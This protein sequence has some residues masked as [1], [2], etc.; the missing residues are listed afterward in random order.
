VP[1]YVPTETPQREMIRWLRRWVDRAFVDRQLAAQHVSLT[2]SQRRMR[3][4]EIAMHVAQGLEYIGSAEQS[5]M[6]TRP[7]P[8]FYAAEN[9]SKALVMMEAGTIAASDFRVHGLTGGKQKRYSIENLACKAAPASRDVWSRI[10]NATQTDL[11]NISWHQDGRGVVGTARAGRQPRAGAPGRRLRFGQLAMRMPELH[12]DVIAAAW[13][14]PSVVRVESYTSIRNTG[15]PETQT[16]SLRLDHAHNASLKQLIVGAQNGQLKGYAKVFDHLNSLE[17]SHPGPNAVAP[18]LRSDVL[19]DLFVDFGTPQGALSDLALH[20]AALF[21][22]SD[23]VR[24]QPEQWKRLL[25][26]HVSEAVLVD[27]YL[28][29]ATRKV[30]NMILNGLLGDCVLFLARP[31]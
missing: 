19:G 7:L 14:T 30:P 22:L 1:T 3:A 8:L 2:A 26:E 17:Y 9:L 16:F 25:D 23:V 10:L 13:G 21:I 15:P 5:S 6:F 24:Y 29:V 12:Q 20:L 11:V 4:R 18:V 28:D 31:F 27:R